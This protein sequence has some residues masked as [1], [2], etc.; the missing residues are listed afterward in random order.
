MR[1]DVHAHYFSPAYLDVFERAYANPADDREL[2]VKKILD[3][4]IRPTRTMYEID[5]RL[6][7]MDRVGVDLQ[8]LSVSIPFTYHRDRATAVAMAQAVNDGTAEACR[9]YPDRFKGF[10]SL[11]LPHVDA[12]LDELARAIDQQG[13]HGIVLGGNV[14]QEPLD[15]AEFAPV[16]DEINRRNLALFI[17]PTVPCGIECMQEYDLAAA[18]GYL[19]DT[20]LAALRLVYSGTCERC[21]NLQPILCH[22]G[23]Y[24][25]YQWDRLD[26]SYNTRPEARQRISKPPTEYLK[27]FFYDNANFHLPALR[28]ALETVGP[29]RFMLGSDYPF[30]VG[31]I[32][33]MVSTFE[34]LGLTPEQR[35]RI[36]SG[37]ALSVLR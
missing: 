4:K 18:V 27:R 3:N 9:K 31:D 26:T 23:G 21:P 22:A 15:K 2:G 37:N 30:A 5:L 32:A 1:V 35:E 33:K 13:L 29:D 10:A 12:A 28:C 17:H 34:A 7:E 8:V 16:F 14:L 25:P 20:C 36:E 6:E 19:L 24:L 11:P